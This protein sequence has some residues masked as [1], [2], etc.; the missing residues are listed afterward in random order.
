MST[1]PWFAL[2]I[3]R[4]VLIGAHFE[5]PISRPPF[6]PTSVPRGDVIAAAAVAGVSAGVQQ[7]TGTSWPAEEGQAIGKVYVVR[8]LMLVWR[9]YLASHNS[10]F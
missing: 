8:Q 3:G 10:R 4:R 2:D 5:R 9:A 6:E 1:W 7:E